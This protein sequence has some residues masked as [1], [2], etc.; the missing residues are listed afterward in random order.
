LGF[1]RFARAGLGSGFGLSAFCTAAASLAS[2]SAKK[3]PAMAPLKRIVSRLENELVA[4]HNPDDGRPPQLRI[5]DV[6]AQAAG[7]VAAANDKAQLLQLDELSGWWSQINRTGGEQFWLEAFGGGSYTINR[8]GKAALQIARLNVSVL[9]TAQPDPLRDLLEAKTDRGFAA[10]YLYVFPE[11]VTGFKR[12]K[13]VDQ[14]VAVTA[15]RRLR[16]LDLINGQ[17]TVCPLTSEAADAAEEW[18]GGHIAETEKAHGAWEQWLGK[19]SGM[20]LRYALVIQHLRWS[21]SEDS[22]EAPPTDIDAPAI[23]AAG[24]FISTYAKPM[25]ARTFN[26]AT[27]P[28]KE[29]QAAFFARF[30]QR[31]ELGEFNARD[32][33]RGILGPVGTLS[34]PERLKEACAILVDA[35]LIR[36]VGVRA[37]GSKGRAPA[38][39]EVN[40]ALFDH[41]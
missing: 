29:R 19:Q 32:V 26:M 20:L 3:S 17:P 9:G 16:D 36:K 11:P 33:Y 40:P 14:E 5:A 21:M 34:D 6:T 8:K 39:Y 2:P 38:T 28:Q 31:Q 18:L 12:P 25:A 41:S 13:S 23:R 10:R 4:V 27:R 35:S 1:D 30:L 37:G 7:E 24:Q 15:L 22:A